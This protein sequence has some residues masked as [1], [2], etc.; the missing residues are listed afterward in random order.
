MSSHLDHLRWDSDVCEVSVRLCVAVW[1][2]CVDLSS[3]SLSDIFFFVV[4]VCV[5]RWT[6][7]PPSSGSI[8]PSMKDSVSSWWVCLCV[9]CLSVCLHMSLCCNWLPVLQ[10]DA[11]SKKQ[12]QQL[13]RLRKDLGA[14]DMTNTPKTGR[15]EWQ[16][17]KYRTLYFTAV[18]SW[19]LPVTGYIQ[20]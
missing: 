3:Q 5:M 2:Q 19:W 9:S 15:A 11:Q 12:Q 18:I 13:E 7:P 1:V 20:C 10:A 16:K 14:V 6:L 4:W 8:D 17:M